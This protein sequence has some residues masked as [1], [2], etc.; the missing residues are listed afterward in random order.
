MLIPFIDLKAAHQELSQEINA[1]VLRV[2]ASGAYIL[3]DE[4]EAFESEYAAF[5]GAK[6]CI[7]VGSGLAALT[8][9]LR[10]F[11]LGAGDE[12]IVP[13][14]TFIATWLAVSHCGARPIP[15]EPHPLTSNIDP[16]LIEAAIT[17]RTKAILP[18]HLYGQPADLDSTSEIAA[19][20]GLRVLEDGAQA[21]G[22]KYKGKRIG[23]HGD[24]VA[25]SFYP[26]KNLGALGDG[27]AVT[28]NDAEIADRLRLLRNYGSRVKYLNERQGYNCRLDAIQAAVLRVKLGHLDAW[29]M[30]RTIA[31]KRY[32][33]E[34]ASTGLVMQSVPAWADPSWHLFVVRTPQRDG[35][36]SYL[37][38]A[39]IGTLIH[40][41][42]PPHLQQAYV[43]GDWNTDS[44]P[45]ASQMASEVLSLPMGPHLSKAAQEQV[46][47]TTTTWAR[48]H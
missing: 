44:F 6:F 21:H 20:Y 18:V 25:W 43:A 5:C 33:E 29:N 16:G 39:G 7:G 42:V 10:A 13:S 46:I 48:Q 31:A 45:I 36:Q 14:N 24:A 1:A 12:V 32:R 41:P 47:S 37:A 26:A 19:R 2:A 38:S 4:V 30:R 40:Y 22:A 23:S 3:G 35:L 28:T 27:G 8:L 11:G 9:A 34:L 15:V 17:P